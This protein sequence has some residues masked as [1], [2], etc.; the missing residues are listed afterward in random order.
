MD[1]ASLAKKL[2][3]LAQLDYD[4]MAGYE[5]AIKRIPDSDRTIRDELQAFH[6]DHRRH[7]DDLSAMIITLGQRA[8]EISKDIK[9][10]LIEGMTAMMS[11]TGTSGALKGM[12]QNER[13][14]NKRYGDSVQDPDFAAYTA[15][16]QALLRKNY[17]DEQRHLSAINAALEQLSVA[18]KK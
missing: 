11:M 1:T 14:T 16:L 2:A 5:Q 13:L 17:Q 15:D 9:G 6:D 8:P 12:Q 7:V 10:R 4:A 18:G 3:S